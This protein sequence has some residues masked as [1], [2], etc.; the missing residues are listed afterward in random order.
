MLLLLDV[1]V[2]VQRLGGKYGSVEIDFASLDPTETYPYLPRPVTRASTGDF[3]PTQG[4]LSFASGQEFADF[5]VHVMDD[6]LPEQDESVFVRLT[7]VRLVQGAQLT[8]GNP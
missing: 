7:G 1:R 2:I 4:T 6:Q 3:E 5:R 8:A